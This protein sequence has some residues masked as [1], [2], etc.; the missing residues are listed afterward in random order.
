MHEKFDYI[1]TNG[2]NVNNIHSDKFLLFHHIEHIE[3]L[4]KDMPTN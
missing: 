2:I 1:S 3:T 4:G